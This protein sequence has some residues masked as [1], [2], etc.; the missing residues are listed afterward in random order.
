MV[1]SLDC[2]IIS[3]AYVTFCLEHGLATFSVQGQK[4]NIFGFMGHKG[5][6]TTAYLCWYSA[7]N[8]I[9]FRSILMI[10]F[11]CGHITV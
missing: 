2:Y 1:F 7:K 6:G 8:A 9:I 5:S 11:L 4:V 10:H 3:T